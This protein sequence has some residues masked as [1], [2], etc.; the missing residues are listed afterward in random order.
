VAFAEVEVSPLT[1]A[2]IKWSKD[3]KKVCVCVCVWVRGGGEY[4][5]AVGPSTQRY[6][7]FLEDPLLASCLASTMLQG[8]RCVRWTCGDMCLSRAQLR[9]YAKVPIA[10]F[11]SDSAVVPDSAAI[12]DELFKRY[13]L[14]TFPNLA[15]AGGAVAAGFASAEASEWSAWATAKLAVRPH[16]HT[17]HPCSLAACLA[18]ESL[19]LVY[20]LSPSPPFHYTITLCAL[21]RPLAITFA[22]CPALGH[23]LQ[24]DDVPQHDAILRRVPRRPRLFQRAWHRHRHSRRSPHPDGG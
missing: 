19:A 24:G 20:G 13:G 18:R 4:A 14:P 12:A 2:Q 3:Y 11:A 8:S 17:A 6:H 15:P 1:K 10:V 16:T 7:C 5:R 9:F 22:T 23:A 21:A